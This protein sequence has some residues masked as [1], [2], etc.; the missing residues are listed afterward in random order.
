M[1]NKNPAVG[2]GAHEAVSNSGA[3]GNFAGSGISS[4]EARGHPAYVVFRPRA[5]QLPIVIDLPHSHGHWPCWVHAV[6][7]K[8]TLRSICDEYVD[9]FW[10]SASNGRAPVLVARFHRAL[11]DAN[12]ALTDID[13]QLLTTDWP[14]RLS[15]SAHS[16]RG[17]GLIRRLVQPDMPIY[18]RL[19]SVGEVQSRIEDYYLPYHAA[20]ADLISEVS[21]QFGFCLHINAQ[22]MNPV[23]TAMSHDPDLPRPDFVVGTLNGLSCAPGLAS[24]VVDL[25]RSQGYEVW[26]NSRYVGAELIRQHAH[27]LQGRHGMQVEINR[28]LFLDAASRQPTSNFNRIGTA[29]QQVI[30]GLAADPQR[31]AALCRPPAQTASAGLP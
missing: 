16:Q 6:T 27:P 26:V 20:L 25:L 1:A 14:G 21:S 9:Q 19:L 5:P 3:E 13:S 24:W 2:I 15:P 10:L 23:G 18:D 7:S 17:V 29:L 28:A 4:S 31:L 12:R 30:D 22:A 11:I 8:K